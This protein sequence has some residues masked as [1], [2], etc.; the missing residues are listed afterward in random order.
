MKLNSIL[1]IALLI[2]LIATPVLAQSQTY[3]H[4]VTVELDG[5]W[6]FDSTFASP[7]ATSTT[8]LVGIGK[9]VIHAITKAQSVPVWWD[10]F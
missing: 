8:K 9:A 7:E 2:L 1:L 6:D 5:E 3:Y 4:E 10:L